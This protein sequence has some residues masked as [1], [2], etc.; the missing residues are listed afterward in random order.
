ML[1]GASQCKGAS[2][3]WL[4]LCVYCLEAKHLQTGTV[5][6][7]EITTSCPPQ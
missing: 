1:P 2:C 4:G 6:I 5:L 7:A 3:C